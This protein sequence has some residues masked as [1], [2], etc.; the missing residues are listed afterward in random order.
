[1]KYPL[2]ILACAALMLPTV[3]LATPEW[4]IA[5]SGES[6]RVGGK[7]KLEIVR[8]DESTP[9]PASL[10]LKI[11][12]FKTTETV[13][14]Y[15]DTSA[16]GDDV[17]HAYVADLPHQMQ[18]LLRIEL[19]EAPSNRLLLSVADPGDP[20]EVMLA[21]SPMVP[22]HRLEPM[23]ENEP[24]LSVLEPV[25]FVAGLNGDYARFQLSFK[26][27][28]FEP[29]STPVQWFPALGKLHFGYT[30]T[31][32][33]N[34]SASSMPF[35]D[36][37]YRPSL[38]W[39]SKL[40]EGTTGPS[41]LRSGYE[42]E[43]NGRDV[44]SS[45]S[46]NIIYFQPVLRKD[47]AGGDSLF[48]APRFYG[49]INQEG[50]P[51]IERYRGYVDWQVRYGDERGWLLSSRIR[52]GTAGYGSA[53]LDFSVP[54]RKPLFSRTGGFLYFQLFSGYGESLLDY[55]LKSPAQ[56]RVGLSIVR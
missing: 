26:Y 2:S 7:L 55:N 21:D 28:L 12:S 41:Y 14:L 22:P 54:L 48:F 17:R 24:A 37:S 8:P 32:F 53:L 1:M 43:S 11:I 3:S 16:I 52:T 46:I 27:R 50:N 38:F 13:I 56:L 51:D 19:A 49:Y 18:G 30:Q 31:S 6:V 10:P 45:R 35:H 44:A 20:I 9:W 23:P 29:E 42:H 33:W 36:T 40:D 39:Q 25:Y 34:M 5:A 47:F 4:L 15:P